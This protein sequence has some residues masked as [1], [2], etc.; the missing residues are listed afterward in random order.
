MGWLFL[1]TLAC[2]PKATPAP[3]AEPVPQAAAEPERPPTPAETMAALE[4]G[5]FA[6]ARVGLEHGITQDPLNP[7]LYLQLTRL[8]AGSTRPLWALWYGE[9]FLLLEP[10][11]PRSAEVSALLVTAHQRIAREAAPPAPH[12]TDQILQDALILALNTSG[13]RA[14]LAGIVAWRSALPAATD[15][16]DPLLDWHRRLAAAGLLETYLWWLLRAGEPEAFAAWAVDH[17]ADIQALRD[18]LNA[19]AFQPG[20]DGLIGRGTGRSTR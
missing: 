19:E 6:L 7:E 16:G 9:A 11:S 10:Y 12:A 5:D 15:F 4:R 17:Q 20:R 3:A 8:Y 14:D 18:F 2:A 13:G 1:A